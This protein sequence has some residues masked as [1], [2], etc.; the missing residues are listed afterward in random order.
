MILAET[1]PLSSHIAGWLAGLV[2]TE[3]NWLFAAIGALV[4]SAAILL[5]VVTPV[6][7]GGVYLERKL[8]GRMQ[9]RRGPNRVGPYGLLQSL[10]DGVKL[11]AKEDIL[12]RGADSPL[13]RFAPYLVF[14]AAFAGF[15]VLPFAPG[16]VA[17]DLDVGLFYFLA[18]IALE[19]VGIVMAGWS[20]NNKW[21]LLG[22]MREVAQVVSYELPLGLAAM[23]PAL[24]VGS[25]SLVAITDYQA[26]PIWKW[27]L[28]RDLYWA[29]AMVP[30]FL[31][32][33]TAGLAAA[34]RAPFDLPEAESELT[35][36]FHTEYSGMR[37]GMFFL[38]E[39]AMMLS[40]SAVTSVLFLGGYHDPLGLSAPGGMFA[41]VWWW[42]LIWF[43]LKTTFLFLSQIVLRWTLPRI[44]IDQVMYLCYKVLLPIGM[45]SLLLTAALRLLG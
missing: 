43:F 30:A 12:Q 14:M 26:G 44:R 34:K 27:L 40:L 35:A 21:S 25:L 7:L 8:A 29:I 45:G 9:N 16:V 2:G 32:F 4:V 37:F 18:L 28:W 11:L 39:Y 13:F 42:G 19:T 24:A 31:L 20:S 15:V 17:A 1:P 36:G 23:C 3:P 10:A 33:Y 5:L 38:P 41:G 6:G 22:A